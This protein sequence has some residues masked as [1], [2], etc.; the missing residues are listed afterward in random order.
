MQKD[1]SLG[2]RQ[3]HSAI[4]EFMHLRDSVD[5]PVNTQSEVTE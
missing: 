3:P 4:N 2:P 1:G 5:E